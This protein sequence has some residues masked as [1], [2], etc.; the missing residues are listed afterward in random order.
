MNE[1]SGKAKHLPDNFQARVFNW[2]LVRGFGRS[3]LATISIGMP[4][5][6]YAILYH[7]DIET[8]LGQLGGLLE[9]QET[10]KLVDTSDAAST[11]SSGLSVYTKLNLFYLGTCFVGV[12]TIVY[13]LVAP[14]T[15]K[16]FGSIS[17][18]VDS[19]L[20]RATARKMRS[21]MKTVNARRP[22]VAAS[23]LSIAP[24][25]GSGSGTLKQASSELRGLKDNQLQVD[26]LSSFYNVENRY[27][28]RWGVYST[29][30]LYCIGFALI[31]I[32]GFSFTFR[33]LKVVG[34]SAIEAILG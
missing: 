21:M 12:G 28:S 20:P 27:F 11:E 1:D 14:R 8:Y 17:S 10:A 24:W 25:L 7:A 18:F 33:V 31:S 13:R 30:G 19:E 3:P 32:P 2:E 26:V 4:F 23:L 9:V 6:G 5:V 22:T 34:R 15:V 29:T 16:E